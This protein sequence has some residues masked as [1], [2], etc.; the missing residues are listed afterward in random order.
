MATPLLRLVVCCLSPLLWLS[1]CALKPRPK[2]QVAPVVKTP[3]S[4]WTGQ[5]VKGNASIVVD[6]GA[7]RA[8]FYRGKTKVGVSKISSGREKF[9]T[10]AGSYRVIQK[11]KDHVSSA[12][13]DY[14]NSSGA[15]VKANV[16]SART[17]RPKGSHFRG[18]KMPYFLRFYA[19]FGLHAGYVPDYPASHGCVRLPSFMARHFFENA[20]L[21]TPV[22]VQH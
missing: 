19:G 12:Y 17:P 8:Y 15:V 10:P 4:Y 21:G 18:A 14:V 6:L 9:R 13:G 22:R 16:S 2:P 5:G 7:Q 11:D 1:G 3:E 20:S